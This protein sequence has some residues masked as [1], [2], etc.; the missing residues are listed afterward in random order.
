MPLYTVFLLMNRWP[1]GPIVCDAW[2][3][4]DYT[5]SNAS[6]ANLLII[7]SATLYMYMYSRL[8]GLRRLL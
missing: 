2:L 4:I 1:L 5:M 6:V 7:R 3:S 8:L